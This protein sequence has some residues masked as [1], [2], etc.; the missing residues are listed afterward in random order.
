MPE[1]ATGWAAAAVPE[2]AW[3][4][5]RQLGRRS[6]SHLFLVPMGSIEGTALAM[7]PPLASLQQLAL[8]GPSLPS[9]VSVN[10]RKN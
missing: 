2:W 3:L 9:E 6:G 5:S 8:D 1:S 7:P 4:L 10:L